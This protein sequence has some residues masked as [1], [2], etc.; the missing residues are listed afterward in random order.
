VV[1]SHLGVVAVPG[2]FL[3]VVMLT[4]RGNPLFVCELLDEML[5]TGVVSVAHIE[6]RGS[7]CVWGKDQKPR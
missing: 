2:D 3:E 1:R 7:V 4:S 6:G 5:R